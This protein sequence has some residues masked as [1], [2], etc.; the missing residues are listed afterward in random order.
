MSENLSVFKNINRI[1]DLA[2][3]GWIVEKLV[4]YN[5]EEYLALEKIQDIR[6][7]FSSITTNTGYLRT[8]FCEILVTFDRA[9]EIRKQITKLQQELKDLEK[10]K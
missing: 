8:P 7:T 2:E 5:R 1:I 3:S 6:A 10:A 4:I 9:A